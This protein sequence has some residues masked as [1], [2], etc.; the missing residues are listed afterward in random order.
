MSLVCR[1]LE[2]RDAENDWLGVGAGSRAGKKGRSQGKKGKHR[3]KK[4]DKGKGKHK[5]RA[6]PPTAIQTGPSDTARAA[7]QQEEKEGGAKAGGA[8]G[9]EHGPAEPV[10]G[11]PA[12]EE[13]GQ[14]E[15]AVCLLDFD[16][17]EEEAGVLLVCGHRFH[18]PCVDLWVDNCSSKGLQATCPMCRTEIKY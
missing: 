7:Q 17:D 12:E 9:S 6:R 3:P 15:C 18:G 2:C 14:E 4:T 13:E 10:E 8:E 16:E 11:G 1:D 5:N